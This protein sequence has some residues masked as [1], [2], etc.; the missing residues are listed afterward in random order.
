MS[1]SKSKRFDIFRR[2]KFTCGYCGQ[3]PPDVVLEVDHIHPVSKGGTDE[4]LNLITACYDCNQG[5]SAKL[6]SETR[7]RPDADVEF[8]TVQQEIAELRRYL[9]AKEARDAVLGDVISELQHIWTQHLNR[10][11]A[12]PE[13]TFR[14][15]L[16]EY[17]PDEIEHAIMRAS[18]PFR[19]GR[20]TDGVQGIQRY[21]GGILKRVRDEANP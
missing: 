10:M 5:K 17:T 20:I 2:D 15:W 4:E 18:I 3:R 14:R 1:L 8:M 9:V 11:W 7:P 13:S 21:V 16:A 19:A 12:P 6:L